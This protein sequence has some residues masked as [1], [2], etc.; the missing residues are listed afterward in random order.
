MLSSILFKTTECNCNQTA[1]KPCAKFSDEA[2]FRRR[3]SNRCQRMIEPILPCEYFLCGELGE[4]FPLNPFFDIDW[5]SRVL[6]YTRLN[7][8]NVI[9]FVGLQQ[10]D[11]RLCLVIINFSTLFTFGSK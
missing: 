9:N 7:S 8:I 10:L 1:R 5:A 6:D 3:F 11:L 4:V 2:I